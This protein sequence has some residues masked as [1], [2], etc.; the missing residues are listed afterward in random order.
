[1]TKLEDSHRPYQRYRHSPQEKLYLEENG[2]QHV[3][4]SN[5][6]S[7]GVSNNDLVIRFHNGSLYIYYGMGDRF[8]K[9][10]A[11]NSKGH[12][13]WQYLRRPKVAYAKIGTLP[14]PDDI[15]ISDEDIF[16]D[17]EDRY[18]KD[19]NRVVQQ[20]VEASVIT[21]ALG[22]FNKIVIGGITIYQ[23]L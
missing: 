16:K 12:W 15:G 17:L 8:D 22:T 3:L 10:M 18:I 7:V 1:M 13:V 11:S 2:L 23:P 20:V 5:V 19:L 9:I 6:S 4:S 21:N 14:L